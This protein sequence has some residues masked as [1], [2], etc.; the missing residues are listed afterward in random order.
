[1]RWNNI[2]TIL[3][4]ILLAADLF[5]LINLIHRDRSLNYIG[6]DVI[7]D[8]VEVLAASNVYVNSDIIPKSTSSTFRKIIR[9]IAI[10]RLS[11]IRSSLPIG[12]VENLI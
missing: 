8:T 5:M 9:E 2:K 10:I 7:E 12:T 3:L 1:M 6:A 4:V 11:T